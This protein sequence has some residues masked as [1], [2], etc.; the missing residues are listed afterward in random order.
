MPVESQLVFSGAAYMVAQGDGG[1]MALTPS[2]LSERG[3]CVEVDDGGGKESPPG[4]M[5]IQD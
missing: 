5:P 4:F 2:H 3:R 1:G